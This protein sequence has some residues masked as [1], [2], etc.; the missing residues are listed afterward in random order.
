MK[1]QGLATAQ[2]RSHRICPPHVTQSDPHIACH[3]VSTAPLL[4]CTGQ[5]DRGAARARSRG[6]GEPRERRERCERRM[7]CAG[8][9]PTEVSDEALPPPKAVAPQQRSS[10]EEEVF[11]RR[12]EASPSLAPGEKPRVKRERKRS[13]SIDLGSGGTAPLVK[14][15][16][17]TSAV[18]RRR[19]SLG[20]MATVRL[21][22]W[23]ASA[24][25][26][27]RKLER[28][29]LT[30]QSNAEL[31][32]RLAKQLDASPPATLTADEAAFARQTVANHFLF[33]SMS[34]SQQDRA[35]Q[36]LSRRRLAP[37]EALMVEGQQE[38]VSEFYIL[39]RGALELTA[40]KQGAAEPSLV[41]QL[42]AFGRGAFLG[43]M[44]LLYAGRR[45]VTAVAKDGEAE[46][47]ALTREAYQLIL[48]DDDESALDDSQQQRLA[49]LEKSARW[50]HDL[51]A[52]AARKDVARTM[53]EVT[54]NEGASLLQ[55]GRVAGICLI[56]LSGTI[57]FR[58]DALKRLKDG[59]AWRESALG[60]LCADATLEVGDVVASGRPGDEAMLAAI[61]A[62]STVAEGKLRCLGGTHHQ[63]SLLASTEVRYLALPISELLHFISAG[64]QVRVAAPR[65]Q[66]PLADRRPV[67]VPSRNA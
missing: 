47:L 20:D 27:A 26:R 32:I 50:L 33:K 12:S 21:D 22:A 65:R 55:S 63:T 64:R 15:E 18:A 13:A 62:M 2:I 54:T 57:K 53:M 34:P 3:V 43:E 23:A 1:I 5:A 16:V 46:V 31:R 24:E 9:I 66:Q 42:H 67:T 48:M 60:D 25:P 49:A 29:A 36:H 45:T 19:N 4:T 8:S 37:Q 17:G 30:G 61:H 51:I 39:V 28:M 58:G 14:P 6:V 38:N 44:A 35:M 59:G 40:T 11:V 10:Q 7:G 52:D 41:S 56:L